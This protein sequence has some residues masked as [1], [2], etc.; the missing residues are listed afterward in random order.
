MQSILPCLIMVI[1]INWAC[2]FL[3]PSNEIFCDDIFCFILQFMVSFWQKAFIGAVLSK[4]NSEYIFYGWSSF[5]SY[6]SETERLHVVPS[7]VQRH[8]V[9]GLASVV[10]GLS[11]PYERVSHIHERP[12]VN[13][14]LAAGC[15]PFGPFSNVSRLSLLLQ[16]V[17]LVIYIKMPIIPCWNELPL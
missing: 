7:Q 11:A 6:V 5:H 12:V 10:G 9:A 3:M 8:I 14:L 2:M 16:D 1:N 4:C 15:H 17:T 13:W